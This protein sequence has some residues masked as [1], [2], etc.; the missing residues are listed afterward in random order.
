MNNPIIEARLKQ[1]AVKTLDDEENALKEIIQEIALY[2]L[3][4]TDFFS[5]AQF[6]GGTALRILYQLPRFSEDLDFILNKLDVGFRWEPYVKAITNAFQFY[7]IEP[8]VS[9]RSKV[10]NTIQRLFLKDDS[11]GKVLDLNFQHNAHKKLLVKLEIDTNPPEGSTSELKYLDFP[12]DYAINSQDLPSNFAGKC[13]ALLCRPYE[14]GRDWFDF[15]WYIS[16]NTSLNLFF[17]ENAIQQYG[18]WHGK[19]ISVT[20]GWVI[21]SLERKIKSM[22]WAK[23][24]LEV[25]RFLSPEFQSSLDLWGEPFFLAKL[26]KLGGYLPASS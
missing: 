21:E 15:L 18:P 16:R 26:E 12:I 6:Q 14:K 22:D 13:H 19:K 17:L 20:K 5:H 25:Q 7:G 10:N 4:T 9:D 11:I 2:G 8:E 3:A 24:K 1:Y 23:A